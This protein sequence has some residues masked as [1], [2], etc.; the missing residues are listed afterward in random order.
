MLIFRGA[1][2]PPAGAPGLKA[3]YSLYVSHNVG[4]QFY[5]VKGAEQKR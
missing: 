4:M 2:A 3:L 5:E 1:N